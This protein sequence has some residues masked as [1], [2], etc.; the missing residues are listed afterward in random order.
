VAVIKCANMKAVNAALKFDQKQ[1]DSQEVQVRRCPADTAIASTQGALRLGN[2][3]WRVTEEQIAEFLDGYN[4]V[5]G[6]LKFHM[7]EEGRKSGMAAVL[8]A[9]EEDAERACKEKQR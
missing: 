4:F 8:F 2:W 7:N 3:P 1:L 6:S 9:S 5:E